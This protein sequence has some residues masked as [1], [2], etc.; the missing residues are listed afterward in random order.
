[1]IDCDVDFTCHM[2]S[3]QLINSSRRCTT[4]S[5]NGWMNTA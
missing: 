5:E 3:S 4:I 2:A 1:M